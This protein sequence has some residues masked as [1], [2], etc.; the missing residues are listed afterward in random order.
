M[1]DSDEIWAK[2]VDKYK[3]ANYKATE[4]ASWWHSDADLGR[5]V[6]TFADMG[7]SRKAGFDD[8]QVTSDSFIELFDELRTKKIIPPR[9]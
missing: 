9:S 1:T 6:E 7:K 3:L 8:I 5:Q 4:I 2:I